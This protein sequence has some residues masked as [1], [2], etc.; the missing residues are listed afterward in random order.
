MEL[1]AFGCWPLS[2]PRGRPRGIC[3]PVFLLMEG[4][5]L[6][7]WESVGREV[8]VPVAGPFQT[9]PHK[10][11]QTAG[12]MMRQAFEGRGRAIRHGIDLPQQ[13]YISMLDTTA[14][15]ISTMS[16]S[17]APRPTP[18]SRPYLV[19]SKPGGSGQAAVVEKGHRSM[20]RSMVNGRR[21]GAGCSG[22]SPGVGSVQGSSAC[23]KNPPTAHNV[24]AR[25]G[26]PTAPRRRTGDALGLVGAWL[27][28]A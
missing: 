1:K 23:Q 20:V 26:S 13:C 15:F 18:G 17:G 4:G 24:M 16:I 5:T 2:P 19:R 6:Q 21:I 28:Q 25:G 7:T 11:M 14:H 22:V 8:E 27:V 10:V 9:I 3:S 12:W